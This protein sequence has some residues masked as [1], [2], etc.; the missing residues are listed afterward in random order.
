MVCAGHGHEDLQELEAEA[1]GAGC[2]EDVEVTPDDSRAGMEKRARMNEWECT[3]HTEQRL[4][5]WIWGWH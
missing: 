3:S 4:E 2:H 1:E 5:G